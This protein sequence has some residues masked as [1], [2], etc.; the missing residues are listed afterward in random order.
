M[1]TQTGASQLVGRKQIYPLQIEFFFD[2]AKK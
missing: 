1:I 2:N